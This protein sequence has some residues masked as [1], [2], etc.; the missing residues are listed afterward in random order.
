MK[1]ADEFTF[2]HYISM[3][4]YKILMQKQRDNS[5]THRERDRLALEFVNYQCIRIAE[6][7]REDNTAEDKHI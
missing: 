6:I 7:I 5:K 2:D 3:C 4:L 1:E